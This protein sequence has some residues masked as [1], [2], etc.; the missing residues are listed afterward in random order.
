MA[1]QRINQDNI[2]S[3]SSTRNN[4]RQMVNKI[5]LTCNTT[6]S[7]I[8][9]ESARVLC[10]TCGR[11]T[12]FVPCNDTANISNDVYDPWASNGDSI[13]YKENN[14]YDAIEMKTVAN[15]AQELRTM[16]QTNSDTSCHNKNELESMKCKA[17]NAITCCVCLET[18]QTPIVTLPCHHSIC[19]RHV[20]LLQTHH[21]C[22]CP[23]C[24]NSFT[25]VSINDNLKDQV[26]NVSTL[27][28]RT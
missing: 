8:E 11:P 28:K 10:A 27:L 19:R 23:I 22:K 17:E 9:F 3:N 1:Q 14:T 12:T 2:Q 18:F 15:I 4:N 25:S 5:C 26:D 6:I 20:Q 7:N 13:K 21:E 16:L 24:R